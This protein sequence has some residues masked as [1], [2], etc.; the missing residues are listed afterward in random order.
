MLVSNV[1]STVA[2]TARRML[3]EIRD[4]E[5]RE[6]AD[7]VQLSWLS[8]SGDDIARLDGRVRALDKQIPELLAKLRS[9]LPTRSASPQSAQ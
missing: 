1:W 6:A 9:T 8:E 7:R 2:W 5:D 3:A 4:A